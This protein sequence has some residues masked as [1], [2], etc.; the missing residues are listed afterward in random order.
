VCSGG[1]CTCA[2][3]YDDCNG[4]CTDTYSDSQN[5]GYCG[6]VCATGCSGG[7]CACAPTVCNGHICGCGGTCCGAGCCA[8]P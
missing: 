3:G 7:T 6:H 8:P 4:V 1:A 5:C 2:P